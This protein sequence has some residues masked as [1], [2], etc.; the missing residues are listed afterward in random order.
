MEWYLEQR[1][2]KMTLL[3]AGRIHAALEELLNHVSSQGDETKAAYLTQRVVRA[4]QNVARKH[5]VTELTTARFFAD[6]LEEQI[7]SGQRI[8]RGSA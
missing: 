8:R 4:L 7:Q 3:E 1:Q 2:K 6:S 5:N